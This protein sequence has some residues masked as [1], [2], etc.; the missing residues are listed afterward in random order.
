MDYTVETYRLDKRVAGGLKL[1]SKVD[2]TNTD[3][4]AVESANP[5]GPR[6]IVKIFETYVTRTNYMS[7]TQ[8]QE[9]YDTPWTCS[10]ASETYWSS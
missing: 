9:R 7:K 6:K 2:Y 3:L 8:F 5:R 4:S 1:V 10:P